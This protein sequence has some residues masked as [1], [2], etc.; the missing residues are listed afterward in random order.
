M[1]VSPIPKRPA[2]VAEEGIQPN[3]AAEQEKKRRH[4]S[5]VATESREILKQNITHLANFR[6]GGQTV[7]NVP[8]VPRRATERVWDL[9][10]ECF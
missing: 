9:P 2:W 1:P 5:N 4:I 3:I 6:S 10:E 7:L 8:V